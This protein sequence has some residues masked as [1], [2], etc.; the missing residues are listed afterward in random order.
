MHSSDLTFI[1]NENGDSLQSRFASLIKDTQ[2]FDVLVGYFYTSGFH[3]V[4]ES[5]ESTDEVRILIG[6]STNRETYDILQRIKSHKEV[7]DEFSEEV[8]SELEN[9]DNTQLVEE[10]ILKFTN[11]LLYTSP[12]PRDS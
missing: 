8:K 4:S 5:L 6:I 12:S 7:K 10:G 1:T 11:C 9:S 3:T 2:Y